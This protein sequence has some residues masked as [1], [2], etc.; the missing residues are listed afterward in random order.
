[1]NKPNKKF[2]YDDVFLR[3]LTLGAISE[4]YRKVR[5]IN[6]WD[7]KEK[8]ITVPVFYSLMGDDR[9]L[10]DAF[11]DDTV[12]DRP[13]LNI[14]PKPRATFVLKSSTIKRDEYANPNANIEYFKEENGILKKFIGKMRFLP[15]KASYE[16]SILLSKEIDYMKCQ[17]SLWEFFFAYKFFYIKYNSIRIDCILEIPDDKDF[18]ITRELEGIGKSGDTDKFIK[19]N[20]DIH[21]YFP[22]EPKETPPIIATD[23]NRVLFKGSTFTLNKSPKKIFLGGNVNKCK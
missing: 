19:F 1:M 11:V 8:L 5:W 17:E 13:D 14:D 7:D 3:S 10:L 22:I 6:K 15:I 16:M 9:F 20:F 18:E 2:N 12:G 23:C 21:S 4:F